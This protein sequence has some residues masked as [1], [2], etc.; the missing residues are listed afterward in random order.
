MEDSRE[1][2]KA[3][4]CL[5]EGIDLLTSPAKLKSSRQGDIPAATVKDALSKGLNPPSSSCLDKHKAPNVGCTISQRAAGT[6][7]PGCFY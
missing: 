2:R 3:K 4:R 6:E 7:G 1:Y 5:E